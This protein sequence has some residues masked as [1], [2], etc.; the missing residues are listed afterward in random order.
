[1]TL[2]AW[3]GVVVGGGVFVAGW[4]LLALDPA[5]LDLWSAMLVLVG[6]AAATSSIAVPGTSVRLNADTAFVLALL[7]R[8]HPEAAVLLSGIN[9]GL[10]TLLGG[11]ANAR[12]TVP[13]NTGAG[14]LS[15]AAAV[16]TA[17]LLSPLPSPV[18]VI[19]AGLAMCAVGSAIVAIMVKIASGKL[20]PRAWREG[21]V[22]TATGYAASG[23][24]AALMA[25]APSTAMLAGPLVA[26]I[27]LSWRSH[28]GH[29]EE[30]AG[31]EHDREQVFLPTLEALVAAI[32]AGDEHTH[33]HNRRVRGYALGF[34]RGLGIADEATL[35]VLG[36]GALLHDVGKI[37]VPASILLA[38]RALTAEE[39]HRVR[40]HVVIG[41]DLIRHVPFPDGVTAVVRHHHER[42]D[43]KGYPD[44]LRGEAIPLAARM[45]AIC[46]A[47]DDLRTGGGYRPPVS[48]EE[49]LGLIA[50]DVGLA[51][52]P[53]LAE[54]FLR[55]QRADRSETRWA[56]STPDE[57]GRWGA[58][59]DAI[60]EASQEQA[61]LF[62]LA[63][64]DEL[65][66]LANR[67]ALDRDLARILA[68]EPCAVM[69]MDLDGFKGI[70]DFFGHRAGDEALVRVAAG[71]GSLERPGLR[72]YRKGGDEF[73]V[74][75]T[76][77]ADVADVAARIGA[78]LEAER[79]PLSDT[80]FVPVRVSIGGTVVEAGTDSE[81]ALAS[82]DAAMYEVK[83]R[84][85][86]D[87]PRG[88]R[89]EVVR[90]ARDD[91]A[92]EFVA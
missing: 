87:R 12:R 6:V 29:A 50:A 57:I 52:D 58:A 11:L 51:F 60:R 5:S 26:V 35:V 32:E 92:N 41:S 69:M 46:D 1:M 59:N 88:A 8:G 63:F 42:W 25:G 82:A 21:L 27:W 34:A 39:L 36:Y 83:Q 7:V 40:T 74:L 89:P 30:R 77:G 17:G 62:D 71:L 22:I 90:V 45:V 10:A 15:G 65:T 3:L 4:A 20:P 38:Q 49:A 79:I 53:E 31:R 61:R 75:V 84:R 81:A 24:L 2:R 91:R 56:S 28:R 13:F 85:N 72:C 68:V 76:G 16:A 86:G 55:W 70:N 80:E 33:G 48:N 73:V 9:A 37:A 66:G 78:V 67:R 19:S 23:S 43:G 18:P 47:Y 14:L 54:A 44:N 64:R